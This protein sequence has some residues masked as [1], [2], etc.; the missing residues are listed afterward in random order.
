MLKISVRCRGAEEGAFDVICLRVVVRATV[1]SV[2]CNDRV[3]I[4]WRGNL[5]SARSAVWA[6]LDRIPKTFVA[7]HPVVRPSHNKVRDFTANLC[8]P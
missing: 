6:G 3:L 4:W 8:P 1:L 2:V 7:L 5:K